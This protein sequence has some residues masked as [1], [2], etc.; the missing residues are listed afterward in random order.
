M[1]TRK[2]ID[3]PFVRIVL[4]L[5]LTGFLIF[6][7]AS[8]GLHARSTVPV[9]LVILKQFLVG[10]VGGI[11]AMIIFSKIHY[12]VY[13]RHAFYIFLATIFITLL[14]YVPGIGFAHGGALRW[15]D[16]GIA[17]FQPAELLKIGSIIYLAAWFS[18]LRNKLHKNQYGL[19]PLLILLGIVGI[20]LISQPDAGTILVI[21]SAAIAM[22]ISAGARARD[23]IVII[24]VGSI[25][26]GG[27]ILTKPYILERFKTFFDP[28]ADARGAG[29]QVQQSLIAI[30]SGQTF[31]RGFGQSIQKFSFLPEP[32]GDSI[33]AVASEEFGFIGSLLLI[34]LFLLFA[35][36]GLSI[37]T[38]APD[39]FGG[40]L[41]MGI[42][43]LI[44]AQSL[45][46][47]GSM[48][49]IFPLTGMPLLFVSHGGSALLVTLASVGIVLNVS[50]FT[51]TAQTE[52]KS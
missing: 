43:I 7:S 4:I 23:I 6:T 27:L 19:I 51:C 40:L 24:L 2:P 21:A 3:V 34:L 41:V 49:G 16:I 37:A 48:L 28:G 33:F 5:T 38:R 18:G 50:R 20:I 44:S 42:V 13:R 29:Y 47:I 32:S 11:A 25:A 9:L 31:G 15:I 35:Y 36:R 30:G 22:F 1:Q 14:V 46:N 10:V 52:D 12:R 26:L 17:T 39:L 8:F 45:I